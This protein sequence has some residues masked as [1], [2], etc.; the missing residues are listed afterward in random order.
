MKEAKLVQLLVL[1]P[2]LHK[3]VGDNIRINVELINWR[4]KKNMSYLQRNTNIL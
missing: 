4:L 1:K 3:Q 2:A